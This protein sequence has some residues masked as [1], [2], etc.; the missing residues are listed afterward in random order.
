MPVPGV[1]RGPLLP[2]YEVVIVGA[3]L[4]GLA[5]AYELAKRGLRHVAVLDRGYPGIGASGRNGEMIRSAF[6]SPEWVGFFDASLAR[7]REL[8]AELGF[9]VLFTP[10]GH[11]VLASTDEELERCRGYAARH[12]ELGV[13]TRLVTAVEALELAPALAPERVLGGIYQAGGGF[14]HHDAALWGYARAGAR[15]GGELHPFT[16]V[17]AIR[18]RAGRVEGVE[19]A[20]GPVSARIVVDAAG[21]QAREVAALAGVAI[22]TRTFRLEAIVTESLAPFLRPGLALLNVLGYCHQTTRGELV[23]GTEQREMDEAD[24]LRCTLRNLRDTAQKLVAMMPALAG[25]RVVRHWAGT[26]DAAA[27]FSPILGP[28]EEVEGL[29]LDCGWLYGFA[30]APA[31]GMLLAEAIVTGQVPELAAPFSLARLREGRLIREG[32]LVVDTGGVE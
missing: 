14:A 29:V 13:A 27:D 28:V 21:G 30:G 6:G 32:S 8:S 19:T 4:Q 26:V 1:A 24:S 12:R 11:L 22:P 16:E 9:N 31:G 10:A 2:A 25:V 3:G 7:W 15:L 18:V 17:T 20:R 5:L 23:G